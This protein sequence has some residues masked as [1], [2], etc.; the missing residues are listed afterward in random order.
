M[1]RKNVQLWCKLAFHHQCNFF[2]TFHILRIGDDYQK[3][4]LV[5][6]KDKDTTFITDSVRT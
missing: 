4:I 1:E 3:H 5:L 2:G 6:Q